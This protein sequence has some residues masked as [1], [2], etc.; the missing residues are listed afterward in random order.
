MTAP[1]YIEEIRSHI[2]ALHLLTALGYTNIAP[3]EALTLRGGRLSQVI[4]EPILRGWLQHHNQV[5]YKGQPYPFTEANIQT[6]VNRLRDEPNNGLLV[7]TAVSTICSLWA[8]ACPKPSTATNAATPCN[9][10]I[11]GD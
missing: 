3:D 11:V 6:A 8:P 4:L 1:A 2:P 9:T 5:Q 10:L 7:P